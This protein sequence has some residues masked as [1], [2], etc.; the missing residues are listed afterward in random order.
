VITW[1]PHRAALA[2][3]GR[4]GIGRQRGSATPAAQARHPIRTAI[5][6]AVHATIELAIGTAIELAVGAAVE[7]PVGLTILAPHVEARKAVVEA[8]RHRGRREQAA[9]RKHE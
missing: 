9:Q 6:L 4:S 1:N 5:R 7:L 3:R 8:R 2:A